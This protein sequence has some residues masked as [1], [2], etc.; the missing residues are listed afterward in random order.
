MDSTGAG[1]ATP[2]ADGG[3]SAGGPSDGHSMLTWV[4][5]IATVVSTLPVVA[6]WFE[7][8]DSLRDRALAV[9]VL[10]GAFLILLSVRGW[11]R[12]RSLVAT[13]VLQLLAW[14]GLVASLAVAAGGHFAADDTDDLRAE[15]ARAEADNEDLADELESA[16]TDDPEPPVTV[17]DGEPAT[18]DDDPGEDDDGPGS[19]TT[20]RPGSPTGVSLTTL[21]PVDVQ[22][23][24]GIAARLDGESFSRAVVQT[25]QDYDP[26]SGPATNRAFVDYD[27]GN[28]YESLT[29]TA[30]ID[31]TSPGECQTEMVV[32]GDGEALLTQTVKLGQTFAIDVDVTDVLRLRLEANVVV[33]SCEAKEYGLDQD[34]RLAVWADP[35]LA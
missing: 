18:T 28:R 15:L 1:P 3:P 4:V 21:D 22:Y 20:S 2:G 7:P 25:V 33:G 10:A 16:T 8:F 24:E 11:R 26:L 34:P 31:D 27:L 30:G 12:E 23:S 5:S 32:Y 13:P 17:D 9:S 19:P 29:G 6:G 35:R 14:S